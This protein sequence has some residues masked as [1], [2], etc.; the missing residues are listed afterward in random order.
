MYEAE[1]I[2]DADSDLELFKS[3]SMWYFMQ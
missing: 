2:S 3:K 1:T